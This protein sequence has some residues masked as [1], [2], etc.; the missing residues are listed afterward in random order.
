ML[1]YTIQQL[2]DLALVGKER[3][4]ATDPKHLNLSILSLLRGN[5]NRQ[6]KR[7]RNGLQ[8]WRRDRCAVEKTRLCFFLSGCAEESAIL[9]SIPGARTKRAASFAA[10][11]DPAA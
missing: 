6:K 1:F 4:G 9:T 7:E 10:T 5:T 11:R 2:V 3:L 8:H